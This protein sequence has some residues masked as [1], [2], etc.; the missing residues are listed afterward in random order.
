MCTKRCDH[1][2][3]WTDYSFGGVDTVGNQ[4][5]S[6]AQELKAAVNKAQTDMTRMLEDAVREAYTAAKA[7]RQAGEKRKASLNEDIRAL[8]SRLDN[9]TALKKA[10]QEKSQPL[11]SQASPLKAK[12]NEL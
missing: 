11:S 1:W 5:A 4:W 3:K 2:T 7:G 12:K 8:K 10:V 9:L 6:L